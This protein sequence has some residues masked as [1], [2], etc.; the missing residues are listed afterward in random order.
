MPCAMTNKGKILDLQ[1]FFEALLRYGVIFVGEDHD[2]PLSHEAEHAI[3]TGLVERD[4]SLV[5]AL[6]MFERDVQEILDAY[7]KGT[8]SEERFLEAA[9]PWANYRSDYRLMVELARA[10]GIPVVAANIPRRTAAAVAIANELSSKVLGTDSVYV[11]GSLHFDSKEYYERFMATMDEMPHTGPMRQ[12]NPEALYKAQILKDAVMAASIEPFLRHHVLF[13]CGS[14][15]SDYHLGIPY[16]L[17][18]NHPKTKIAV[19][20]MASSVEDLPM[21]ERSRVADFFWIDE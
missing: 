16:Q 5:L 3:L 6:E 4:S 9:R 17:Q 12:I 14:F 18:K 11:P 1:D 15:H 10:K 2:S 8:I 7:L 20:T 13:I 19:I 21:K